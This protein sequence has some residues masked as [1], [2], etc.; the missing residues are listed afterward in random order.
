MATRSRKPYIGITGFT[1]RE[2]VEALLGVMPR[3]PNRSLMVGVLVS[4]KTLRGELNKYPNR[5]PLI[6]DMPSVFT[7]D[8]LV[9]NLIHYNTKDQN[10]LTQ[11]L[12]D[13]TRLVGHRLHGFQLNI[14]WPSRAAL[15]EYL[16]IY[17]DKTIVLQI[18]SS[19][20]ESVDHSPEKL[21]K[22][23]LSYCGVINYVLLDPS[24]GQGIKFDPEVARMYLRAIREAGY[25][26]GIGV[27]GGLEGKSLHLVEPLLHEFPDISIDAEGKLRDSHD[28]LD[29]ASATSY[30]TQFLKLFNNA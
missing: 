1:T 22:K 18:G 30:L 21:A 23:V 19:A 6:Q 11:E 14:P 9:L 10:T 12:L 28:N 27:A 29:I 15:A 16:D 26:G 20:F 2:Q 13:V 17:L 7:N 8:P 5:Y 25:T 3:R 4:Q 24:G